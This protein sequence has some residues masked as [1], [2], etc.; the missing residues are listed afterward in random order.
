MIIVCLQAP[1]KNIIIIF[2]DVADYVIFPATLS[3]DCSS[4][5][6]P[7]YGESGSCASW[8]LSPMASLSPATYNSTFKYI[9]QVPK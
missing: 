3:L 6:L 1:P 8:D 9:L 7:V 2:E 5:S 4:I